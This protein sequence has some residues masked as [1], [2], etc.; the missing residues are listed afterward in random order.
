MHPDQPTRSPGTGDPVPVATPAGTPDPTIAHSV[1]LYPAAAPAPAPVGVPS[2]THPH[3]GG[4]HVRTG[5][6]L[7]NP[8]PATLPADTP[9]AAPTYPGYQPLRRLGA[10]GDGEIWLFSLNPSTCPPAEACQ[11]ARLLAVKFYHH[12]GVRQEAIPLDVCG[13]EPL[14]YLGGGTYGEVLLYQDVC[15]GKRVAIKFFL[16]GG[17]SQEWQLLQAEVKQLAL[18]DDDPGIVHI[19]DLDPAA[20]P[21]YYIMTYAEHG[22]LARRLE[23]GPMPASEALATFGQIAAA[24]AYVHAKGVR[25]CDLKPGNILLDVRD[26]ALV[27]DFGQA[28]LASDMSP[29]LGTFFYMAP[30]Q[31]TLENTIAD[32]RWDVYGLGALFYAMV[33]GRPP[34]EDQGMRATIASTGQLAQAAVLSRLGRVVAPAD[35]SSAGAGRGPPASGHHRALPRGRSQPPAARRRGRAYRAAAPPSASGG[36]GRCS[37]SA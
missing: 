36:A 9:L 34:H 29:A 16:R 31:A 10:S 20:Q 1:P 33:V 28:H 17:A 24:L 2:Q 6:R 32:T 22:S 8:T 19:K 35:G 27:A 5:A 30:E 13:Y 37:S 26:R 3:D 14:D 15:T 25:H 11:D 23:R 21:P 12:R 18:L 4:N 7:G